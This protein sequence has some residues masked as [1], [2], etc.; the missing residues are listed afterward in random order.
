MKMKRIRLHS[1]RVIPVLIICFAVLLVYSNTLHAPFQLDDID[2]IV[3]NPAIKDGRYFTDPSGVDSKEKTRYFGFMT[4]A[5]NYALHGL[6]VRGYH[7]VNILI[8]AGTALLL[9]WLI[10]LT[11]RTPLFRA[12]SGTD[13]ALNSSRD[14]IAVFSALFFAVHPIQTQAVTYIVQRFAS[15]AA[16]FFLLALALYVQFRL[17]G[18]GAGLSQRPSG[19]AA[20]VKGYA[21]YAASFASAVLAMKTKEIAIVLPPI[22]A[23]YEFMFFGGSIKK[24]IAHL[25]PF[26]LSM[27]IIPLTLLGIKG[28][29]GIT[30]AAMQVAGAKD[31]SWPDYLF[32]QFR[33]IVTYIRLLF[34]P[35]DQSFDYDYPIF[36]SLFEAQ[37]FPSFVFLLSIFICG[38][39]LLRLS[40]GSEAKNRHLYRLCAFGIFFFFIALSV[41]SSV[42]PI[43]D[44][45][46]EHRV[47]LPS[48]GFFIAMISAAELFVARWKGRTAYARKILGL[49]MVPLIVVL[50][51][52]AYARNTVWNDRIGQ[53]EDDIRKNPKKARPHNA[54]GGLLAEQGRIEEALHHIR[55]AI[56]LNPAYAQA[57]YSLGL[58]YANTGHTEEA[59]KEYKIAI[60]LQYENAEAH[61][62]LGVVYAKLGMNEEAIAEYKTALMISPGSVKTHNNLGNLYSKLGHIEE[63]IAEYNTALNLKPDFPEARYNMGNAYAKQ[64]DLEKAVSEYSAALKLKPDFIEARRQLEFYT[65]KTRNP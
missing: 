47:Y 3:I 11:F 37:V 50:S 20:L 43:A 35:V 24:R 28:A 4:F 34:L 51:V 39:Y 54:L 21:V 57:H 63:A 5:M 48:A 62:N 18:I 44:V 42:F 58:T 52:A 9:Y 33:V 14:F 12:G 45:I 61:G 36:H 31:I 13:S 46:F 38:G 15:L 49:A 65:D 32:T 29:G 40:L 10:I 26:G 17:S 27:I 7:V 22:I 59:I 56:A 6:D 25:V 64:G 1:H 23:L 16:L 41:E 19:R 55:T 30:D 2:T 53:L 60:N 8:H